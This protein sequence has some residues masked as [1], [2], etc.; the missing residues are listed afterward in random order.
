M[1]IVKIEP[2]DDMHKAAYNIEEVG[3]CHDEGEKIS[4]S[5]QNEKIDVAKYQGI[6]PDLLN[7]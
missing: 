3:H 1:Y 5:E 7:L 6:I 2:E 4:S